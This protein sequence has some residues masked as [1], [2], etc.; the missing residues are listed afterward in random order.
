MVKVDRVNLEA[1]P[2]SAF[3]FHKNL[4]VLALCDDILQPSKDLWPSDKPSRQVVTTADLGLPIITPGD[5]M[6]C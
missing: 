2:I 4:M 6:M 3:T 1:W 5:K